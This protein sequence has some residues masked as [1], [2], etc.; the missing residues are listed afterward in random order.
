M[1]NTSMSDN[2]ACPVVSTKDGNNMVDSL[3]SKREMILPMTGAPLACDA[4]K[5]STSEYCQSNPNKMGY[6]L[7]LTEAYAERMASKCSMSR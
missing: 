1:V 5:A 2:N 6:A 7:A 3:S 4:T